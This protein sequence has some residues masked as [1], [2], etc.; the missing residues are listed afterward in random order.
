MD[1]RPGSAVSVGAG[2]DAGPRPIDYFPYTALGTEPDTGDTCIHTQWYVL[3]DEADRATLSTLA[4]NRSSDIAI[5][6]YPMPPVCS[7]E[8]EVDE[9]R[10][11]QAAIDLIEG[12]IEAPVPYVQP[13]NE[14]ITGIRSHLDL[15]VDSSTTSVE[16]VTLF[17]RG[18]DVRVEV[19]GAHTVDWGDGSAP[20]ST[21]ARGGPWHD[22]PAG[23][24]DIT[25]TYVRTGDHAV[26]VTSDWTVTATLLSSGVTAT[27]TITTTSSPVAV[28]VTEV[29]S[30]RER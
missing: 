12:R 24:D 20:V 26:S 29:V 1:D 6:F 2:S 22:G 27:Q 13:D 8:D 18:W 28:G 4:A 14:A 7:W 17:S 10:V 11:A 5:G 23:P 9:D 30:V 19:E 16:T 3:Y 15:G 25:H 21:T